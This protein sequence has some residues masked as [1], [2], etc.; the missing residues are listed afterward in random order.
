MLVE[1]K[2]MP[3]EIRYGNVRNLNPA[4][5]NA[6]LEKAKTPYVLLLEKPLSSSH[7]PRHQRI[8]SYQE[9]ETKVLQPR[10]LS[11]MMTN[12]T[13]PSFLDTS[14]GFQSPQ[15]RRS[16][17]G[18][19]SARKPDESNRF[20]VP[21][22]FSD[23]IP[24][25]EDSQLRASDVTERLQNLLSDRMPQ[26]HWTQDLM[27]NL[28]D[29][30]DIITDGS[31]KDQSD[32]SHDNSGEKDLRGS[33]PER[34]SDKNPPGAGRGRRAAGDHYKNRYFE[35]G[36]KLGQEPKMPRMEEQGRKQQQDGKTLERGLKPARTS[37]KPQERTTGPMKSQGGKLNASTPKKDNDKGHLDSS[38]HSNRV[39]TNPESSFDQEPRDSVGNLKESP[40][41]QSNDP[42]KLK[43][44]MDGLK[45]ARGKD[46]P[47][48][49]QPTQEEFTGS[50]KSDPRTQ[51][52]EAAHGGESKMD[53]STDG[54]K[55]GQAGP[56][57]TRDLAKKNN[58]S[59]ERFKT[60]S[61]N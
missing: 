59:C 1:G 24:F 51:E 47:T 2:D 26:K 53:P 61:S 15:Q 33:K 27:N 57:E 40:S 36:D 55:L 5:I 34:L 41:K 60:N 8:S 58:E 12:K 32:G 54:G 29:Q 30:S 43:E 45:A 18:Y 46:K 35:E 20:S 49:L 19:S 56:K 3:F 52:R 44:R 13:N 4:V 11:T 22:Q 17:S 48:S 7:G 38:I 14:Q 42:S 31:F 37:D 21:K 23:T 39:D 9:V 6:V 28:N 16:M 50:R 10:P 25:A